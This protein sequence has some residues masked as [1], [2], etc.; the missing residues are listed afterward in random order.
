MCLPVMPAQAG[1]HMM[2]TNAVRLEVRMDPSLRWGDVS[3]L[4]GAA[5]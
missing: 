3:E 2:L 4:W 5:R 1:I